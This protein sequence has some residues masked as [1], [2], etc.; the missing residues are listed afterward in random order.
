LACPGKDRRPQECR[1]A[2]PGCRYKVP[3][4]LRQ[5]WPLR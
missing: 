5:P 3:C 1:T 4:A 2:A